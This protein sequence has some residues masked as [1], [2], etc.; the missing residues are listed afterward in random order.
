MVQINDIKPIVTIPDFSIYL[1]YGLIILCLA[2][3]LT[4]CFFIY[5]FF[6]PKSKTKEYQYYQ[7]LQKIDFENQKQSAYDICKYGRLLAKEERQ[8]H[9]IEELSYELEEYKYKKEISKEI[10]SSIKTKFRVF[11]ESIDV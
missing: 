5:K 2:L 1:Y 8:K 4:L 6:K 7:I 3:F 10:S 9:L 11:M